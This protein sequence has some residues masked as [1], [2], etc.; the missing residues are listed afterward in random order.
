MY[1][2]APPSPWWPARRQ[3][4]PPAGHPEGLD[5]AKQSEKFLALIVRHSLLC[6]L[7]AW[8]RRTKIKIISA[9]DTLIDTILMAIVFCVRLARDVPPFTP[10]APTFV[11]VSF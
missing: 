1:L 10:L 8:H 3:T 4:S 11:A 7:R 9:F 2:N 6:L 5:G